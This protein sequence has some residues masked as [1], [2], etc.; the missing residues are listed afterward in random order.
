MPSATDEQE[1]NLY[2]PPLDQCFN[3]EARV[4]NWK[5]VFH[6]LTIPSFGN[7]CKILRHFLSNAQTIHALTSPSKRPSESA[8][9]DFES[10]TSAIN[11]A[12]TDNGKYDI[13]QIK[14]DALWLS[15]QA[16]IDEV[17][18][19]RIVVIEW[20]ERSTTRLCNG[21]SE[22]EAISLQQV[23]TTV[24][25]LR[26]SI[27]PQKLHNNGTSSNGHTDLSQG[28][29][30]DASRH[31]RLLSTLSED[32][33][34]LVGVNVALQ[35]RYCLEPELLLNFPDDPLGWTSEVGKD[36][37]ESRS[38]RRSASSNTP[39]DEPLQPIIS[40]L[41]SRLKNVEKG[42]G[43]DQAADDHFAYLEEQYRA[44]QIADI[45]R[46]FQLVLIHVNQATSTITPES[47][48]CWFRLMQD[49]DFFQF[50]QVP[51]PSQHDHV[52]TIQTLV[53]L[54]SYQILDIGTTIRVIEGLQYT[55]GDSAQLYVYDSSCEGQINEALILA[56]MNQASVAG[57]AIMAWGL[58]VRAMFESDQQRLALP[59]NGANPGQEPSSIALGDEVLK[60]LPDFLG[61][62]GRA[63]PDEK[64][65]LAIRLTEV[66]LEE[67]ECFSAISDLLPKLRNRIDPVIDSL[68]ELNARKKFLSLLG[69]LSNFL[70]Y[71]PDIIDTTLT[72]L[73]SDSQLPK[74][75]KSK[76][77]KMNATLA[78]QFLDDEFLPSCL[79]EA[80]FFRFPHELEPVLRLCQLLSAGNSLDEN[81]ESK[82]MQMVMSTPRLTQR[83]P[84]HFK[85]YELLDEDQNISRIRLLRD[86]PIIAITR[87]GSQARYWSSPNAH[88]LVKINHDA[89]SFVPEGTT[90]YILSESRPF[91]VAWN[92]INSPLR[93]I[94]A[95]L[96]T[97][98]SG[99]AM[100]DPV[101]SGPPQKSIQAA[102]VDV[103]TNLV[104]GSYQF[105]GSGSL[106]SDSNSTVQKILQEA[107]TGL[108]K[109]QDVFMVV[110]GIFDEELARSV[111]AM[112]QSTVDL[113]SSCIRFFESLL[114][115]MPS[116]VWALLAR[117]ELLEYEGR[118]GRIGTVVASVEMITGRYDFLL[119]CAKFLD[120][121]HHDTI[122][123]TISRKVPSKSITHRFDQSHAPNTAA[124]GKAITKVMTA[125]TK[126]FMEVLRSSQDWKF[127]SRQQQLALN[128]QIMHI[129]DRLVRL[130]YMYD[131]T[132]AP[133]EKLTHTLYPAAKLVVDAYLARKGNLVQLSP[134]LQ[135][136]LF[137][138]NT[139]SNDFGLSG[140]EEL[141]L[142]TVALDFTSTL[143]NIDNLQ[144]LP[145]SSLKERLLHA[146]PLLARLY[147]QEPSLTGSVTSLLSTLIR[148]VS[149]T[150]TDPPSIVANLSPQNA[151]DFLSVL[152]DL[153][154]PLSNISQ[155]R[156][157][158]EFFTSAIEN[159]QQW[160]AAYL[161]TG[162][163]PR[164]TFGKKA[165]NKSSE[166]PG[167]SVL[168][169]ALDSLASTR[170]LE[171]PI[172]RSIL[173][174][175]V[176]V[177]NH[178]GW[179]SNTIR[180]HPSFLDKISNYMRD[181]SERSTSI[182]AE[183]I[184]SHA[185][186]IYARSL[187]SELFAIYFHNMRQT[188]GASFAKNLVPKIGYFESSGVEDPQYSRS[189]HSRLR[190]N[191]EAK[192]PRCSVENF[193]RLAG[194]FEYGTSY[195]FDIEF[196]NEML[197]SYSWW[198][199]DNGEG[200][201]KDFMMANLNLSVVEA[202]VRSII[203]WKALAMELTKDMNDDGDL[204]EKCANLVR[205]CLTANS[206]SSLPDEIFQ[207]MSTT[208]IEL[209]L[210]IMR[211]LVDIKSKVPLM[212]SLLMDAWRA[213]L[214]SD[215]DFENAFVGPSARYYR[216]LLQVLYCTLQP[217]IYISPQT[218]A[219]PS[220]DR[221]SIS[222]TLP[223]ICTEVI[224]KGFQAL[225]SQLHESPSSVQPADFSLI[226]CIF[227]S[228]LRM[229]SQ[230]DVHTTISLR[231]SESSVV[232]Y[233]LALFSWSDKLTTGPPQHD[234]IYGDLSISF[235]LE[236][237]TLP[238]LAEFLATESVL[239]Q[240]NTMNIMEA[241]RRNNTHSSPAPGWGQ[242]E[243]PARLY[244]IWARGIL[245]LVL[246][247]LLSVGAPFALEAVTFLNNFAPQLEHAAS[248]A[249][250]AKAAPTAANPYAGS[251]TLTAA[252][253]A[254]TL[255]LLS[256]AIEGFRG[257]PGAVAG[258]DGVLP[259][260]LWD[261]GAVKEDLETWV[262]GSR[263]ALR[264]RIVPNDEK[265][266]ELA[267]MR[268]D[269]VRSGASVRGGV[270]VE[271]VLEGMV[272]S[273]LK[274][275][276][277]VLNSG[278]SQ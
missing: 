40:T 266:V 1:H 271:N 209:A 3:G 158:W 39:D 95:L 56:S 85:D 228:T 278:V 29:N 199:R 73:D 77:C 220:K 21:Y 216:S 112:D 244:K 132:R 13:K 264:E 47:I 182:D 117:S 231:L 78:D 69:H 12:P 190:S 184:T 52:E 175:L 129:F 221:L 145:S 64:L 238:P 107:N 94:S 174:F 260:L 15:G 196:A 275:A 134:L 133:S 72:V 101:L 125:F 247:V 255:A 180:K 173:R 51:T 70:D 93:H 150:T 122:Y 178:F 205:Q 256:K 155:E 171:K 96:S 223:E 263:E 243:P 108:S 130:V 114:P 6:A 185:N 198:R 5:T 172:P 22:G 61:G 156:S 176:Q 186:A 79:L 226:N 148:T 204:Q 31:A 195:C 193:K 7:E 105:D 18:A 55:N 277:T 68:L 2:L 151:L 168:A 237:S 207:E 84:D 181:V 33:S 163:D 89:R 131:D 46:L 88:S 189:L 144:D 123:N 113:L 229:P 183:E 252:C 224:A 4:T 19:L 63:I 119:T 62:I 227:Q 241:F 102:I 44:G 233:A 157:I 149:K 115:V 91:V 45:I 32:R 267:E 43:W 41:R 202:Q 74:L 239:S 37:V 201:V 126:T 179:A 222:T 86:L 26:A 215:H 251:V 230:F 109:D 177:Q 127:A 103:L 214:R 58:I 258:T 213:V 138:A 87:A 34:Y 234:P 8:K 116:R 81:G 273:E 165:Q 274:G 53:S 268:V 71:G 192:L 200:F 269:G 20:Q 242:F 249:L 99:N 259:R 92:H 27:A 24:G 211:R 120:K 235:L 42:S 203:C 82:I 75:G 146:V 98:L 38:K 170:T 167:K 159:R 121:L 118:G 161:L 169:I 17:S 97:A 66:S 65:N 30:N 245:P 218:D 136:G 35:A 253:E 54:V 164:G 59:E 28:F 153:G 67:L 194:S 197:S 191:F 206:E 57:P 212:K 270:G 254:H 60:L 11:L 147:A 265:E 250:D 106:V 261:E 188:A 14:E 232:R 104:R 16:K 36:V 25:S 49:H 262:G 83:L 142:R 23:G 162:N 257:D 140:N 187:L 240:L 225:A 139:K 143:L 111:K 80:A 276:L 272:L 135:S 137:D 219:P 248:Y 246:N 154:K 210:T 160:L 208:R 152:S 217:H 76:S 10:L 110:S 236:M 100:I 141:G 128:E 50:L 90:G 124:S 48:K 166:P 9:A